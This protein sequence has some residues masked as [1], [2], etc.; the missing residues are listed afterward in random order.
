MSQV[1]HLQCFSVCMSNVCY[2]ALVWNLPSSLF[3]AMF[4]FVRNGY[5]GRHL[6]PGQQQ[7]QPGGPSGGHGCWKALSLHLSEWV[8]AQVGKR[9][10]NC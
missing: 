8:N 6:Y 3:F 7:K 4:L 1:A 5:K 2:D 10:L 9:S